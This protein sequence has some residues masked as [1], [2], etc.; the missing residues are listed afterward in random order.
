MSTRSLGY[1]YKGSLKQMVIG[2]IR[3]GLEVT[4]DRVEDFLVAKIPQ[5]LHG[6]LLDRDAG[7]I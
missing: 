2:I 3:I 5:N 1:G 6:V 4:D 7:V